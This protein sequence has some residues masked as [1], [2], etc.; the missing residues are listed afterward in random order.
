MG[1]VLVSPLNWGL[2]HATRDIPIIR[3]LLAHGHDVTIAGC[4]NARSV[5]EQE[6]PACA[7]RDFPDYSVPLSAN[8]FFL[9]RF[10]ASSPLLLKGIADERRNLAA[11]LGE[12]RYD[13]II[14]DNR[15]G[16]YSDKIPSLFITHQL[17]YHL[18]LLAW[19]IELATAWL[20]G[21]L[22]EKF[23]RVIV[24]DNPPGPLSLAGKLS[25]AETDLSRSRSYYAGILT[26]TRKRDVPRDLDYLVLISGPEP[27]R[28]ELEKILLPAAENLP[29]SVTILLGSPDAAGNSGHSGTCTVMSY[30]STGEKEVLMNRAKCIICR[31]G[32]TTMMELAELNK[33]KALLI[34]TP[35]QPEQEYLAEYYEQNGW[36]HGKEQHRLDLEEDLRIAGAFRGFPEVPVTEEN[37]RRL[38]D[39]VLAGYLE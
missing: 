17:H 1:R 30:A 5:L 32:Y 8:N 20:N 2:G 36:F 21:Y 27:Q 4:G 13:L 18:P 3:T 38:Y 31:S 11:I 22:H 35:G 10:V 19:P 9:A 6:F 23:N 12:D 37:V 25:R 15:L 24:P 16:V 26:S 39:D 7:C 28:T 33:H 34:P 29:G 14:S